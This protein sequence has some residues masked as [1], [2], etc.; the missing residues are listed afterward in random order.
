MTREEKEKIGGP[1]MTVE[2]DETLLSKRK[3]HTGRLLQQIWV[4]GGICREN[5][6]IFMEV[7]PN[8][9]SDTLIS[10]IHRNI[11]YGSNIISDMWSGYKSLDDVNQPQPYTHQTVNHIEN[12]VD[13]V[14]GANTQ[15]IE[16]GWRDFKEKKM[17]SNGIPRHKA[18]VYTSEYIW[19][20][21]IKAKKENLF[22]AACEMLSSIRF[23]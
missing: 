5:G 8:R 3:Y 12:F 18:D 15:I 7:V 11:Q 10:S 19:R 4:F 9:N 22:L 16:R 23:I 20:R 14:S 13:P 6:H 2:I 17:R 1:G 21:N